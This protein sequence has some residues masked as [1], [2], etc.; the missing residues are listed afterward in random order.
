MPRAFKPKHAGRAKI[1]FA[2]SEI[3]PNAGRIL[4]AGPLSASCAAASGQFFL[5]RAIS[6]QRARA[7]SLYR[8]V[9]L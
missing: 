2:R 6:R 5:H 8:E 4:R 3:R 7:K 1:Y 9:D